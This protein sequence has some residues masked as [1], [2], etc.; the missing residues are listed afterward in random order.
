MCIEL[1]YVP[2]N[3][4]YRLKCNFVDF[5]YESKSNGSQIL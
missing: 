3:V 2:V 1:H 4:S 5:L